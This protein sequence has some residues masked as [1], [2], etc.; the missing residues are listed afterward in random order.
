MSRNLFSQGI[1]SLAI[2]ATLLQGCASNR[3]DSSSPS[4][5]LRAKQALLESFESDSLAELEAATK[6]P[7]GEAIY[8][9]DRIYD[10]LHTKLEVNFDWKK[11]HLNGVATL[12][13][14]PYFYP[15]N[16]LVLD[17][18]GFDI[19][20][21]KKIRGNKQRNLR[22]TYDN[23]KLTIQLDSTYTRNH[24]LNIE[25]DYTAKPDEL[26]AAGSVAIASDK[27]LYFINPDGTD[28]NKPKQ[29]WTQ[30]ETQANSKWFPTIDSPNERCTQE[31]Y[32][33]VDTSFTTLS[34]GVLTSSTVN[35]D[36]TRTDVWEMKLP[37]APYL[38]MM[39]VG[40]F[41]TIKDKWRDIELTYLV[42]PKY[43]PI[44]KKVF[45]NTPEMLEFF[46]NKLGVKYP[47]SKYAQVV[48]RDYV[49]GAME[50]TT[51]SLFNEELQCDEKTLVDKNFDDIISHELFHHWFGDLVT[52]ESWGQLPLNESFATYAEYLWDEH[53]YG[54][55]QADYTLSDKL[56]SYLYEART[57]QV[58]MIRHHYGSPEEMFDNHSYAKGGTLLH[59]L[60]NHVGDEAFFASLKKYLNDN[61]FQ[62]A[63]IANLRLAFEE[64]TGR[65]MNKFFNQ[66]FTVPG[67]PEFAV[68]QLVRD[69]L[70]LVTI[71]QQQDTLKSTCYRMDFPLDV[72]MADGK[73]LR[74]NLPIKKG[75]EE[76]EL[77]IK[78]K[79]VAVIADPEGILVGRLNHN[80]TPAQ[81][82]ATYKAAKGYRAKNRALTY[83]KSD[84]ANAE[85]QSIYENALSDKFWA[86]RKAAIDLSVN[87]TN[88]RKK[89]QPKFSEM[90]TK[91]ANSKVRL[92]ALNAID[93]NNPANDPLL[94]QA[95]NDKG[96]LVTAGALEKYLEKNPSDAAEVI[97]KFENSEN[98]EIL[99]AIAGYKADKGDPKDYDWFI[100]LVGRTG[101]A[102]KYFA[103]Q[104][105]GRYIIN[106][107]DVQSKSILQLK[108]YATKELMFYHRLSAFQ[109]LMLLGE[110]PGVTE[111]LREI[112][113][114]ETHP[115]LKG[116]YSQMMR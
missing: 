10:L 79:P 38:F 26:E 33:T 1:L 88:F 106:T 102:G 37:H 95:L 62:A 4:A 40:K 29:I 101:M 24:K 115:V 113:E 94:K 13:L 19:R 36:G 34:N 107:P 5:L 72:V 68:Q 32:I 30:G 39:T 9:N 98:E 14:S 61:K 103:L 21:V 12:T 77:A 35:R 65:D 82:R 18:V 27:G 81:W 87:D 49:S 74:Y 51:A 16:E 17:A 8:S 91:D 53:K 58:P 70:V 108:H 3:P 63:E 47:W 28:P 85:T 112:A 86:I 25:I 59:L 99:N 100:K 92:S 96:W 22:Y 75:A 60:R 116:Y 23:K 69:S 11:K 7:K 84:I 78:G 105:F 50:N 41:S 73:T 89:L 93:W 15:Q 114:A 76:Y 67:H 83:L 71:N 110:Q 56:S 44:A 64:V 48:V 66:W 43:A 57:K 52:C 54:K 55:D 111:L 90:L 80:Q 2:L 109:S 97:A 42:E 20:S 46:S 31:M 6:T 45:G 104:N